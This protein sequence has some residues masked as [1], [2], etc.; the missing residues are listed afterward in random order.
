MDSIKKKISD[1]TYLRKKP[2]RDNPFPACFS[3]GLRLQ[4][5]R[6]PKKTAGQIEEETDEH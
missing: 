6:Q 1:R 2:V 5:S 4:A 3:L